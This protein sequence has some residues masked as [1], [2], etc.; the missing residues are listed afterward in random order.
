MAGVACASLRRARH[1]FVARRCAASRIMAPAAGGVWF[2]THVPQ[3]PA[4]LNFSDHELDD[5]NVFENCFQQTGYL[6]DFVSDPFLVQPV[7]N[8]GSQII[9]IGVLKTPW[10][11]CVACSNNTF[12]ENTG[13]FWCT[14]CASGKY[15]LEGA[16]ECADIAL[17]SSKPA[18]CLDD[19]QNLEYCQY[20]E[21]NKGYC[22]SYQLCSLCCSTCY[23][24]CCVQGGKCA[25]APGEY[26][27][28][29]ST[30]KSCPVNSNSAM[31][32]V[33]RLSCKCTDGFEGP[34]GGPC[35]VARFPPA[36]CAAGY[37]APP[38]QC[39][40]YDQQYYNLNTGWYRCE[41][42]AQSYDWMYSEC[43]NEGAC[44]ICCQECA[45]NPTCAGLTPQPCTACPPNSHSPFGSTS[46]SA[47]TCNAGY[48]GPAGGT[49]VSTGRRLL[50]L[51]EAP[52][53]A[54]E[55]AYVCVDRLPSA[56][57]R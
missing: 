55:A 8:F 42:F 57:R 2:S 45:S 33:G 23:D 6:R 21:Q 44:K 36:G 46:L 18:Y 12:T 40:E 22:L 15:S 49:C 38:Q 17:P 32:S 28:V 26:S 50:E 37:W 4:I 11:R 48:S 52:A 14:D 5:A 7:Y 3:H 1:S 9:N 53:D 20:F 16:T 30:C 24:E 47:C 39:R 27:D 54:T 29:D 51:P 41:T 34:D 25:C 43:R 10:S 31:G 19:E 56:A 13:R 35:T